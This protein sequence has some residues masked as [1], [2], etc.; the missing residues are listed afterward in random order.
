MGAPATQR[1]SAELPNLRAIRQFVAD[2]AAVLGA[3]PA[4]IDD[5]IQAVDEMATNTIVHGYCGRAGSVEILV[6]REGNRLAVRLRDEA[7][8]F[9]PAT[10]SPPNS[11]LP[12]EQRRPGGLGIYL[13]RQL[14]DVMIHR[15]TPDGGNELTLLKKA[16]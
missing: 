1:I 3:E 15:L 10:V 13:S 12:F 16:F 4:A 5:M 11:E 7:P 2:S 6:W 8:P 9:D 14:T